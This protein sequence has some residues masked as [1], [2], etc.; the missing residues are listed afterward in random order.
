MSANRIPRITLQPKTIFF[1]VMALVLTGV[2]ILAFRFFKANPDALAADTKN[3]FVLPIMM[4]TKQA[5]GGPIPEQGQQKS[6]KHDLAYPGNTPAKEQLYD[7]TWKTLGLSEADANDRTDPYVIAYTRDVMD[8][9]IQKAFQ[10]NP[11]API[12]FSLVYCI[13]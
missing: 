2:G 8:T 13:P 3:A 10:K 1:I 9:G 6:C 7:W 12:N 5:E 4:P 11:E